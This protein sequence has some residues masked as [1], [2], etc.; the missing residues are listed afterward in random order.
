MTSLTPTSAICTAE[1]LDEQ[2]QATAGPEQP[3]HDG[4]LPLEVDRVAARG[5]DPGEQQLHRGPFQRVVA[6]EGRAAGRAA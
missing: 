3:A 4:S 1:L 2:G 5:G 6:P